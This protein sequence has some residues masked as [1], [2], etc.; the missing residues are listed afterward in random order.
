MALQITRVW[1]TIDNI[2]KNNT[3]TVYVRSIA[4]PAIH[5]LFGISAKAL[6][7]RAVQSLKCIA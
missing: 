2:L 5:L 3:I 4:R 7:I 1:R 6:E